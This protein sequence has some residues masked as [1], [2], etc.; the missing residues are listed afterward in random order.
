MFQALF[1]GGGIA[2][3]QIIMARRTLLSEAEIAD[4]LKEIPQWS[5]EGNAITRTWTFKDFPAAL[6]FINKVGE[7]AESMNH[8]PDIRNSWATVQLTLTTHDR[9]GLTH[10]DFELAK[11]IDA[12]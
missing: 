7:L 8:H 5:R 11:K 6:R 12:L 2:A 1:P 9:G 4:R 10:L 3:P